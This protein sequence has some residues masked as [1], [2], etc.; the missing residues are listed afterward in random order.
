MGVRVPPFAP[1][2]PR[3]SAANAVLNALSRINLCRAVCGFGIHRS[4]S[5]TKRWGGIAA[6]S[7]RPVQ[8]HKISQTTQAASLVRI[9]GLFDLDGLAGGNRADAF[10]F[11]EQR[12]SACAILSLM[13]IFRQS[14]SANYS[15]A[16]PSV[17]GIE[18]GRFTVVLTKVPEH[19][20]SQ[21]F[22]DYIFC[23][24]RN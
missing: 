9:A 14:P 4:T 13:A 12:P 11:P 16:K 21:L 8:P 18:K 1:R 15:P 6:I 7:G 3:V 5:T 17:D 22:L 10:E 2:L 24:G 20:P 23:L 19:D